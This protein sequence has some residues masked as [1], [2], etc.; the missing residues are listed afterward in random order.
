MVSHA[1]GQMYLYKEDLTCGNAAPTYQHYKHGPGFAIYSC[2]SKSQR[3]PIFRWSIG[4]NKGAVV[5]AGATSTLN[6]S[7]GAVPNNGV[8]EANLSSNPGGG[9]QM[10]AI[11][12][13]AFSP[14]GNFLAVVS[15][16]GFLRVFDYD[17]M[18]L[19]GTMRSYFGGLL[20]LAWSSDSR[21]I[22]TGGEDD[23]ITIWS[24]AE[25][26][27]LARGQGHKSWVNAVAFDA[28]MTSFSGG[29]MINGKD[30][31]KEANE[32]KD[33]DEDDDDLDEDTLVSSQHEPIRSN[34][35]QRRGSLPIGNGDF[36]RLGSVG[37]D[38]QICLWDITEDIIGPSIQSPLLIGCRA[39]R[40][41]AQIWASD[42]KRQSLS[43]ISETSDKSSSAAT[44]KTICSATSATKLNQNGSTANLL[45]GEASSSSPVLSPT[46]PAKDEKGKKGFF[47]KVGSSKTLEK[48]HKSSILSTALSSRSFSDHHNKRA[49]AS[50]SKAT[51]EAAAAAVTVAGCAPTGP[52]RL[53]L[54]DATRL[55]G[56]PLCP[57]LD[58]VPMIEP[59]VAKKVAHERLTS[60][61]FRREAIVIGNQDGRVMVFARPKQD[62]R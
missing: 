10:N 51:G 16:D 41:N 31:L 3:N 29:S 18:D 15:Q 14:C 25:R 23:L 20:C 46:P 39:N 21:L 38:T 1:S 36:Y 22:A 49:T 59:H 11:N 28:Y 54:N 50:H 9:G 24:V 33:E 32:T 27:V 48:P 44:D 40:M 60:I 52:P 47:F 34:G 45:A 56:T 26:R 58:G 5:A 4:I 35:H 12:E 53:N 2:K 17:Q 62:T 19:V 42:S 8:Y 37:Q 13:F 57:R 61:V 7:G 55:L 43:N 30:K 6:G